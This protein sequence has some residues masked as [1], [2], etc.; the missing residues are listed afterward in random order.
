MIIIGLF[1]TKR[2]GYVQL[3]IPKKVRAAKKA[4]PPKKI[5][6]P[7]PFLLRDAQKQLKR[8]AKVGGEI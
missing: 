7:V 1:K 8:G 2:V 5:L 3:N 4:N 6:T